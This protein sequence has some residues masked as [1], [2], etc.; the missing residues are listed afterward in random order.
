MKYVKMQIDNPGKIDYDS[1]ENQRINPT[2][3]QF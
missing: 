3:L 1:T 2:D